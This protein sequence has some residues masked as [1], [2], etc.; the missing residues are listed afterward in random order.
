V[1]LS[2]APDLGQRA[3]GV[4]GVRGVP[5]V[6]NF[7]AAREYSAISADKNDDLLVVGERV[8]MALLFKRFAC[9]P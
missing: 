3:A 4:Y 9:V 5:A 6:A 8:F 1:N 2:T 7:P